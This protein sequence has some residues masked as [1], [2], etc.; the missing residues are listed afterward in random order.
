MKNK[1]T[2]IY[3]ALLI[4]MTIYG[5]QSLAY[6]PK[7]LYINQVIGGKSTMSIQL[8]DKSKFSID[9]KNFSAD[10]LFLQRNGMQSILVV[11]KEVSINIDPNTVVELINKK[12]RD[13]KVQ[14]RVYN[15]KSKI[16][17]KIYDSK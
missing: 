8:E 17:H 16:I 2:S 9:I 14:V 12:E 3:S 10:T 13:V 1:T 5:C 6:D 7:S 15:H 4:L 11:N